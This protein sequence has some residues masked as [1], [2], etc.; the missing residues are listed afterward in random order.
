MTGATYRDIL[1][2]QRSYEGTTVN[3][4]ENAKWVCEASHHSSGTRY[5]TAQISDATPGTWARVTREGRE[6]VS[7]SRNTV[8]VYRQYSGTVR[9]FIAE[10]E[11]PHHF[12]YGYALDVNAGTDKRQSWVEHCHYC[13][14]PREHAKHI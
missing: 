11:G 10:S 12:V 9:R 6:V 5:E 7:P 14:E 1:E 2:T 13:D 8:S 4:F 3:T